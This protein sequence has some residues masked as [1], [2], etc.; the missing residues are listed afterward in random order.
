[1]RARRAGFTFIELMTVVGAIGVLAALAVPNY[2]PFLLES[3]AQEGPMLVRAVAHRAR[4]ARKEGR[5]LEPCGL[6]PEAPPGAEA[7]RFEPDACWR[8]LGVEVVG[9]TYFQLA[10]ELDEAGAFTVRARADLDEDGAAH[11]VWLR[12]G[13]DVVHVSRRGVW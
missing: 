9:K 7:V 1:M 2:L 10:L 6:T 4:V 13:E 5:A 12:E 3:K 11:E 8:A